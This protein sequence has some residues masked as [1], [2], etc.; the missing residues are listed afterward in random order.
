[1]ELLLKEIILKN[2]KVILENTASSINMEYLLK[3]L[4]L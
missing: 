2:E 1:M 3:Y 4:L